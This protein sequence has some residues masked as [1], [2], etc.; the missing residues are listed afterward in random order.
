MEI[1]ILCITKIAPWGWGKQPYGGN[2]PQRGFIKRMGET[3]GGNRPQRGFIKRL[4][5]DTE[6]YREIPRDTERYREI[7]RDTERYREIPRD[8]ERYREI[9]VKDIE[10]AKLMVIEGGVICEMICELIYR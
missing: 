1:Q 5:R 2:R 3:A 8:T 4:P 10:K 9:I 6:R 7:P